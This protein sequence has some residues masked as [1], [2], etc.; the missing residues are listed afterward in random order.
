MINNKRIFIFLIILLFVSFVY[1]QFIYANNKK[2][3]S[4]NETKKSKVVDVLINYFNLEISKDYSSVYYQFSKNYKRKLKDESNVKT[5]DD[6]KRLRFSSESKWYNFRIIEQSLDAKN[7]V[8]FLVEATIQETGEEEQITVAYF[9]IKEK[10]LWKID[11]IY[12]WG[13]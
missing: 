5:V 10:I 8:K 11:E 4:E 9:F 7:R 13:K 12:Y 1:I 3:E 2:Y 6:Y